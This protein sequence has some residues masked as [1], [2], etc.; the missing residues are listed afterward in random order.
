MPWERGIRVR[1]GKTQT[2]LNPG[3]YLKLP[4][5]D[6][7]FVESVR[8]RYMGVPMQTVTSKDGK[9]LSIIISVGYCISD[10]QQLYNTI[11]SVNAT[12][13][14]IVMGQVSQF[15]A[16]NNLHDCLPAKIEDHCTKNLSE[17]D[18]G[19]GEVS[20]K[21]IGFAVVRTYRLIQDHTWFP[22]TDNSLTKPQ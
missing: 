19:L 14:N 6:K 3:T 13:S 18:Y 2:L 7:V 15:V 1:L 21:V 9:T 11:Y 8:M 5:I 16:E 20:I 12:I 10:I 4:L 17:T 22:E